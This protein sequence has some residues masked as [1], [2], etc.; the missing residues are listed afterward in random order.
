M[1]LHYVLMVVAVTLAAVNGAVSGARV[2]TES[3]NLRKVFEADSVHS[4][5]QTETRSKRILRG[6]ITSG[7]DSD[8]VYHY[9]PKKGERKPFIEVRL[10]KALTNPT[11]TLR[12]YER[13]YKSGYTA[14]QVAKGLDQSENKELKEVYQQVAKGYAVYLKEKRPQQ[15]TP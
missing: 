2:S 10:K 7:G 3:A 9:P 15:Q 11:K 8:T 13:W 1:R 5:T 4:T 12:L 6:V 14:K